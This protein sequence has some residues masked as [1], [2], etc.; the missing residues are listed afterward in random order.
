MTS[1]IDSASYWVSALSLAP[2]PEGGFFKETYRASA[3]IPVGALGD[4]FSGPRNVATGI[5]YLLEAGDF[6]AFHRIRSDEMWHFYAG[7]A[8]E[9]HI[10]HDS[11]HEVV[12]IGRQ[13]HEGEVLQYVVPAGAWFAATPVTGGAYSLLGCTVSPGFDFADF[14]MANSTVLT[15]QFPSFGHVIS[16][17]SR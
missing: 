2:H 11:R 8:L 14:E 1:S 3:V 10:L 17:F 12:R 7:A 5:Y 13:V 16:R 4:R 15:H 6:S 9:L